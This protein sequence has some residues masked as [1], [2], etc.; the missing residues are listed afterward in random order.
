VIADFL[1]GQAEPGDLVLIMSN[2]SFDGLC[3]KLL[4]R[5]SG[6]RQTLQEEARTR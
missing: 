2:G 4:A 6:S 5:L 3:D 1:A